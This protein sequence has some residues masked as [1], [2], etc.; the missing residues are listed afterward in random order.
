MSGRMTERTKE[1]KN[2]R[3]SDGG[4]ERQLEAAFWRQEAERLQARALFLWN[5]RRISVE[6]S[7]LENIIILA[8]TFQPRSTS[9]SA[10]SS[11]AFCLFFQSSNV[12][13]LALLEARVVP[14]AEGRGARVAARGGS[15]HGA[16]DR[17]GRRCAPAGPNTT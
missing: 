15:G 17:R 8:Y 1:R 9:N 12:C 13:T 7:V 2:E 16:R 5:F 6:F 10:T 14:K 4:A 11:A 3:G